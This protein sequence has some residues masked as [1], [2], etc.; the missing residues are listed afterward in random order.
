M[1]EKQLISQLKGLKEIKPRQEWAFSLKSEIL[2]T[3]PETNFKFQISNFKFFFEF[4]TQ[5]SLA[6]SFAA[7]IFVIAGLFGFAYYTMPGD[8]AFPAAL[9][10][11]ASLEQ[12]V[13][14]LNS[15]LKDLAAAVAEGKRGS[16][17]SVIKEISANASQLAKSL[18]DGEIKDPKTIK[19]IAS[20]LKTLADVPGADLSASPAVENLYQT[21]VE[22]QITDLEKSTLTDSQKETLTQI[23][24]LY[25]QEKYTDALEKILTL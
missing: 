19:E 3:K 18:K 1:T 2:S 17:P 10:R 9:S 14:L 12:D 15:K 23:K 4:L 13:A 25:N 24:E 20:S 6:Y 22:S 7:F 5:K 21:I 11:Q 16:V 8:E